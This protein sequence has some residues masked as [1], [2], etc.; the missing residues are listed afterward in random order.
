MQAKKQKSPANFPART[1]EH[2]IADLS[3]NHIERLVLLEGW[4]VEGKRHDYGYD[5]VLNTYD[6]GGDPTYQ[7]GELESGEVLLQL[8]ATD[9]LHVVNKG[10]F[11]SFPISVKHINLWRREKMPVI[12]VIYDVLNDMAYWLYTQRYFNSSAFK[13]THGQKGISLRIPK[14]SVVDA[15]AIRQFREYKEQVLKEIDQ[16]VKLHG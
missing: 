1:R 7:W 13:M 8:K 14:T 16:A 12:L 2:H 15:T 9:N 3:L 6:Y 11:I 4:T 10:L 5:L